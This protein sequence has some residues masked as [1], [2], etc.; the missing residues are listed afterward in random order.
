MPLRPASEIG[1]PDPRHFANLLTDD[2]S[3][4]DEQSGSTAAPRRPPTRRRRR[5]P[6]SADATSPGPPSTEAQRRATALSDA[7]QR[8]TQSGRRRSLLAGQPLD[9]LQVNVPGELQHRVELVA[10]DMGEKHRKLA[11]HQFIL[12]ALVWRHV[13]HEDPERLRALGALLDEYLAEAIAEAP[14]ERRLAARVPHAL[15][16]RVMGSA[17]RLGQTHD[18]VSARAIISALVWRYVRSNEDDPEAFAT[19]VECVRDY[20]AELRARPSPQPPS[21]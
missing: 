1:V 10:F 21:P 18:E 7:Q 12:G 19:L 17:L 2:Q 8:S 15:K 20:H 5:A 6:R 4:E 16:R 9:F 3:R 14:T 11:Q 13:D